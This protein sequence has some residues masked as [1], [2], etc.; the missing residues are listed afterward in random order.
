MEVRTLPCEC[1]DPGW[2]NGS[3]RDFDPRGGGSKPSPGV[4]IA[5]I[6]VLVA[7]W[8]KS[9]TLRRWRPSVRIGPRTL[10]FGLSILDFGLHAAGKNIDCR[11]PIAFL[12]LCTELGN[13]SRSKRDD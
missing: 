4:R 10:H 11:L 9:A 5:W 13:G 7:Q 12:C 1:S 3:M 2:C 8:N 6:P